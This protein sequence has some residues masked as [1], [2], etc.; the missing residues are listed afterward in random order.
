MKKLS[1]KE[2][3]RRIRNHEALPDDVVKWYPK[4]MSRYTIRKAKRKPD[5]FTGKES[6]P[7]LK[8][9]GKGEY[10]RSA[11]S[12]ELYPRVFV[13]NPKNFYVGPDN[14]RQIRHQAIDAMNRGA[15]YVKDFPSAVTYHWAHGYVSAIKGLKRQD[16]SEYPILPD[17]GGGVPLAYNDGYDQGLIDSGLSDMATEQLRHNPSRIS[18]IKSH[19]KAHLDKDQRDFQKEIDEDDELKRWL[20][21]N[22]KSHTIAASKLAIGERAYIP[23]GG[24]RVWVLVSKGHGIV[25][26]E[27][28]SG[29]GRRFLHNVSPVVPLS[30]NPYSSRSRFKHKRL[31]SPSKFDKRSFRTITQPDGTEITIGCPKGKWDA[32][33]KR[34]R[35]GTRAQRILKPKGKKRNSK[36]YRRMRN[37]DLVLAQ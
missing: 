27:A 5:G 35:V 29:R 19:V 4:L 32:K 7:R 22:P 3:K 25:F 14:I 24:D 6:R 20:E 17:E 2:V 23:G 15:K 13:K 28:E 10:R 9:Y 8:R 16:Y 11:R 1:L 12:K 18:R 31:E 21:K 36:R 30:R 33:R 37:G 34:C 26:F